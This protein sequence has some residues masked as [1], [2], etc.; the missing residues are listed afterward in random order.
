MYKIKILLKKTRTVKFS[1]FI[2]NMQ[3]IE[4]LTNQRRMMLKNLVSRDF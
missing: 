4:K 2:T 3:E 1:N